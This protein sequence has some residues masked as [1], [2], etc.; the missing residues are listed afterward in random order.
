[1]ERRRDWSRQNDPDL[2]GE[3]NSRLERL[4][5]ADDEE[6]VELAL[7]PDLDERIKDLRDLGWVIPPDTSRIFLDGIL[8]DGRVFKARHARPAPKIPQD[9]TVGAQVA[10]YLELQRAGVRSGHPSVS[11]YD[12]IA[13][14][15]GEFEKWLKPESPIDS[16]GADR[17]E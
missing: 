4:D 16:I 11:E 7:T 14:Y 2:A 17:W 6:A 9:R 5:K 8:G 10:R 13:R 3:L 12:L 15:V 1:M